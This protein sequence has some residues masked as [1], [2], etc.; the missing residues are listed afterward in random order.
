MLFIPGWRRKRHL[1]LVLLAACSVAIHANDLDTG[2]RAYHD[3][4]LEAAA[5]YWRAL[6]ESGNS[7][8][9]VLM[10]YLYKTGRGVEADRQQSARWYRMAAEQG[11]PNAQYELGLLYELGSGVAAD[12]DEAEYWYG[13]AIEQG[14][15]PGELRASGLLVDD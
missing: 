6:A 3:G 14:Y 15:C 11:D 5:G 10:G 12:Y 7:D 8:A 4:R 9:Q 2:M 13:R 1:F